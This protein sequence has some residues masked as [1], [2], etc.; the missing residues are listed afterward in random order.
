VGVRAFKDQNISGLFFVYKRH[1]ALIVFIFVILTIQINLMNMFKNKRFKNIFNIL[2][3]CSFLLLSS[4][5]VAAQDFTENLQKLQLSYKL[6]SA[7]Y[8]DSV[9]NEK[10]VEDAIVGMLKNLDPHSEYL[11]KEEVVKLNEPLDGSFEGVGVQ[12]NILNDTLLIV[13]PISGGPSEK[14]GIMAGDRIIYIN[15]EKVAGIGLT[16]SGVQQRLKG[17]KGTKVKLKIQRKGISKLLDFTVERD[18][19]PIYSVEAHYMAAPSVGYVKINQFSATTHQEVE[20]A[21]KELKKEGMKD[22]ILDLRGNPGGYLKSAI[23]VVDEFMDQDK[24]IVY[25][26]GLSNPRREFYSSSSGLLKDAKVVVLINEGSASASEIVSGAI[27]DWDRGIL[28]GRRSFGKGLVQRPLNLQDGSMIKLTIA[29]YYTPSGRCIQKPYDN[30]SGE[31]REEIYHRDITHIESIDSLLKDNKKYYTRNSKRLVYAGGGVNPDIFIPADTTGYSDYYR[32]LI[33]FGVLSRFVLEYVDE[34]RADLINEY[35]D[36]VNYNEK[37]QVRDDVIQA[38]LKEGEK[39]KITSDVKGLDV[40]MPYLKAQLKALIARNIWTV[41]E[42]YRVM[43]STY[44]EYQKALEVLSS[45]EL[46]TNFLH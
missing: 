15:D 45:Q 16:N 28:I 3:V 19:I 6:I 37:Y 7:F 29:K 2:G 30:G 43:N 8:V 22:L 41:N 12:F 1:K 38:L 10:L 39:E 27:Q 20:E 17:K 4:Q 31:Y 21:L 34:H 33:A 25:T 32:D 18:K 44:H 14:V 24:L 42:Y 9:D 13:S 35:H 36:F 23:D 26:E 5:Q 46:Y 11:S 40:S